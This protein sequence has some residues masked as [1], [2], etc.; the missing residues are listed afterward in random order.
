MAKARFLKAKTSA[1]KAKAWTLGQ[2]QN[3]LQFLNFAVHFSLLALTVNKQY[4][5]LQPQ[6]IWSPFYLLI[7]RQHPAEILCLFTSC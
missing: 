3:I 2:G 4:A 6:A 7:N 1:A 5:N